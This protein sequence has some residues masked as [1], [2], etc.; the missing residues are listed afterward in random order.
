MEVADSFMVNLQELLLALRT[1]YLNPSQSSKLSARKGNISNKSIYFLLTT[2]SPAELR[3]PVWSS[4][5]QS[6]TDPSFSIPSLTA[7]GIFLQEVGTAG[8]FNAASN[9]SP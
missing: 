1:F 4:L 7:W 8:M 6:I 2:V 3:V 5:R 9:F